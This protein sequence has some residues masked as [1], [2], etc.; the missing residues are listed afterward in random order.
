MKKLLAIVVLGLLLSSNVYAEKDLVIKDGFKVKGQFSS[1][2]YLIKQ[3]SASTIILS[4]GGG[5]KWKHQELWAKYLNDEGYNVVIIDHFKEKGVMGHVGKVNPLTIPEERVKDLVKLSRWV[6]KQSWNNGK[7]GVIGFSQ[8]GSGVN[9]LGNTREVKKIKGVKKRDLKLFGALVSYYPG[10]G[11]IGGTPPHLPYVPIMIHIA[12][13]DG[14]ADPFWCQAGFEKN[15]NFF[16]YE[17]PDAPHGF[18]IT[19][20][21]W[22]RTGFISS[23]NRQYVIEGH[24]KSN[25]L[26]RKRTL[27]FLSKHLH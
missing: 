14:L 22:K 5:G 26:S 18:D 15:E 24:K 7:L 4:H 27:E 10:C 16:I 12:M 11:I 8:G 25:L 21:G 6:S 2:L 17:Y 3:Q 23:I 19:I 9:L 13:D 20:P 1:Q